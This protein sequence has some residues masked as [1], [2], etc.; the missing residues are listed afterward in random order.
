VLGTLDSVTG[1]FALNGLLGGSVTVTVSITIGGQTFTDSETLVVNLTRTI[2]GGAGGPTDP[3]TQFMGTP[4][5]DAARTA[6]IQYPLDEVVMP[7]NVSPADV[8][9]SCGADTGV[10]PEAD[11]FRVTLEKP[12]A[13]VVVYVRNADVAVNDHYLVDASAWRALAQSDPTDA[14]SV[15]VDRFDAAATQVVSGVADRRELRRRRGHRHRLLLGHRRREDPP[16]QRRGARQRAAAATPRL[17][18]GGRRRRGRLRG[19]SRHQQQRP[20]HAGEPAL[21][22]TSARSTT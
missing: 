13:R 4:V 5:T 22:R 3:V 2:G 20:L 11:S 12:H 21:R 16:D 10:C 15:R 17:A 7:Q 9:W 6:A 14:M 19:L 18:A 1:A 8:Q